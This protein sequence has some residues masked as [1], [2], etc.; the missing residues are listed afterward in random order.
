MRFLLLIIAKVTLNS[1]DYISMSITSKR[2]TELMSS[3]RTSPLQMIAKEHMSYGLHSQCRTRCTFDLYHL[4]TQEAYHTDRLN[5]Q[6]FPKHRPVGIIAT[7]DESQQDAFH[8]ILHMFA[9]VGFLKTDRSRYAYLDALPEGLLLNIYSMGIVFEDIFDLM[10]TDVEAQNESRLQPSLVPIISTRAIRTFAWTSL[11]QIGHYHS[12]TWG[13]LSGDIEKCECFLIAEATTGIPLL[14]SLI[15]IVEATYKVSMILSLDG[16]D[17]K[18]PKGPGWEAMCKLQGK[19][20]DFEKNGAEILDIVR[21]HMQPDMQQELFDFED[22]MPS[23]E[24]RSTHNALAT[25]AE[26]IRN[27]AGDSGSQ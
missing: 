14:Q 4:L 21:E 23:A 12:D 9:K 19:G 20:R 7:L 15:T 26:E 22:K 24:L 3:K 2:I 10:I 16:P 27:R 5:S 13:V 6:A 1:D 25:V 8:F 18:I 11:F 17:Y